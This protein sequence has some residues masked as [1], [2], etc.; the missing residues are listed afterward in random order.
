MGRRK[1]MLVTDTE[2]RERL[3]P[4]TVKHGLGR[5]KAVEYV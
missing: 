4:R 2:K 1:K 5:A 3:G